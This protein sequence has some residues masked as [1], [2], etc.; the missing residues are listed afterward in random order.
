[1][2]SAFATRFAA[3]RW[4]G[5]TDAW[6]LRDAA[7]AHG[8]AARS[9]A[10]RVSATSIWHLARSPEPAPRKGIMPGVRELLDA[11]AAR[12]DVYLAL[13]TGNYEAGGAPEARIFRSLAL[14]PCGAFGTPRRIATDCWRMRSRRVAACGGPSFAA[15]DAWCRRHTAR[16]R[17]RRAVRGALGCGRDRQPQR[18]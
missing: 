2:C 6:I 4:P 1:M 8:V 9:P 13:L 7:A 18:R 17:V 10:S 5:R 16:R 11:L 14:F 15:P 12:D 3:C